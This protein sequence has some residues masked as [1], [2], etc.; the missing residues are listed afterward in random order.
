MGTGIQSIMKCCN[1]DNGGI[2][3]TDFQNNKLPLECNEITIVRTP[4]HH[5]GSPPSCDVGRQQTLSA[6]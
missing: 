5:P 2:D 1:C 3:R 4:S 6:P